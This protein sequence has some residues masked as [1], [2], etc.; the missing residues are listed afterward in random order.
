MPLTCKT[1]LNLMMLD[2][3]AFLDSHFF[4]RALKEKN[5][6]RLLKRG[7]EE[8]CCLYYGVLLRKADI[9]ETLP[10]KKANDKPRGL[11]SQNP[12]DTSGSELGIHHVKKMGTDRKAWSSFT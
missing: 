1:V 12:S 7:L 8:S 5:I 11:L 2:D 10:Q 9:F 4:G 3:I 6:A